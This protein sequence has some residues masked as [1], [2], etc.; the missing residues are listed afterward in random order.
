MF[1]SKQASVIFNKE[2]NITYKK[3]NL[4]KNLDCFILISSSDDNLPDLVLNKIVDAIIDKISIKETYNDFSDALEFINSFL[5]TWMQNNEKIYDLDVVIW[6][7]NRN[8]FI[9]SNIW[10]SSCYLLKNDNDLI[11]ITEK[12][13]TKK[14]FSFI[15]SWELS[16]EETL[17]LW[18]K[19]LLNYLS[20]S[21]FLD[22]QIDNNIDNFTINI[23]NIL[24]SEILEDNI[25]V[26]CIRYNTTSFHVET[27]NYLEKIKHII[28][29]LADN[30]FAKKIVAFYMLTID[31]ISK[32][33]K[34][35]KNIIFLAWAIISFSL[36]YFIISGIVWIT[37]NTKE[38]EISKENL[39]KAREYIR[40]ASENISNPEAFELNIKK[41]EELINDITNKDLFS[42]DISKIFDD[43]SI[44]KKQF[45]KVE[46]LDVNEEDI[47]YSWDLKKSVKILKNDKYFIILE[48]WIIWPIIPWRDPENKSFDK[49]WEYEFFIDATLVWSNIYLL[50]NQSNLV[51]YSKTWHFKFIDVEN[52]AKWENSKS[53]TSYSKNIYLTWK[54]N[55]QI[56]KHKELWNNFWVWSE[57]LNKEDVTSIWEILSIWID[58]WIYIL[59]KDLSLIKLF[60]DPKYRLESIILNNLP[61]NYNLESSSRIEIKTSNNLNY[62]YFLLNNK[63]WVFEPNTRR[64]QDTKSLTYIGQIRWSENIKD[65]YI[66]YDWEVVILN[67]SSIL[68][69]DF[70]IA[71][72]RLIL[73]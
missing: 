36:L 50:T 45:N 63:I 39:V 21:D 46:T 2:N 9:F 10:N 30:K 61:K 35:I 70:E 32:Q 8:N 49:L 58:W 1:E 73:K 54:D 37:N 5:K 27:N 69:L 17:I 19:R 34:N 64:F 26:A 66:N 38:K 16:D 72:D 60:K 25:W 24:K 33:S 41:S 55:A 4:D 12:H 23:K 29:H 48:K 65:F 18:T 14:F 40:L 67:D 47:I 52:Q 11:E 68:K 6:I 51:S 13:E 57:Y 53:I 31:Y 62:V 28:M 43:I 56:F 22:W 7:L 71:E 3:I 44:I 42:N 59:K 15:S 20:K